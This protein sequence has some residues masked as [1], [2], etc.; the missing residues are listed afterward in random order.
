MWGTSR[1]RVWWWSSTNR[2][3]LLHKFS[4]VGFYFGV[5]SVT[6]H[7][8]RLGKQKLGLKNLREDFWR[9]GEGFEGLILNPVFPLIKIQIAFFISPDRKHRVHTK[10]RFATPLT[11][12]R[13]FW[14]L[15]RKTRLVLL[16]EWLTLWPVI[17][18]FPQTEHANAI[19]SLLFQKIVPDG[20]SC[21][22]TPSHSDNFF[23]HF[24]NLLNRTKG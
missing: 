24:Q 3:T 2:P 17:R 7:Q 4:S 8:W 20:L 18:F 9:G 14:R 13:T 5:D 6:H 10:T 19:I 1:S 12:A 21:Y 11:S 15:G 22:H 16:L 23:F